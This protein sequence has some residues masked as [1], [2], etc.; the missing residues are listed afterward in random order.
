M[1]SFKILSYDYNNLSSM[2]DKCCRRRRSLSHYCIK[3]MNDR[4]TKRLKRSL[5]NEQLKLSMIKEANKCTPGKYSSK[6]EKC[7]I[8]QNCDKM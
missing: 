4:D 3:C 1:C 2:K 7:P 6:C 8:I 5:L